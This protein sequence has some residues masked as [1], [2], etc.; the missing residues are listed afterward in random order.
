LFWED[1][2]HYKFPLG[3]DRTAYCSHFAVEILRRTNRL[4]ITSR[5]ITV[6]YY[7]KDFINMVAW[8]VRDYG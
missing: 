4:V 7:P 2:L 6:S 8:K 3:H 5:F 1:L